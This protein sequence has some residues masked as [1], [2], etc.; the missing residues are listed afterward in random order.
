MKKYLKLYGQSIRISFATAMSYR[1]DF[2]LHTLIMI[3]GNSLFPLVTLMIYNTGATFPGWTLYEVLL[4]Q[5]IFTMAN[6]MA[7]MLFS[8]IVWVTMDHVK[9]GTLEIVLIKPVNCLFYLLATTFSVEN[10]AVVI[11]GFV[12]FM[13][14]ITHLA[15]ATLGMWLM[16]LLFFITGILVMLSLNLLMAATSFKWVAN[17]RIPELF[18]SVLRFANYPNKIFPKAIQ[19]LTTFIIPVA[20]VSCFPA[21]ALLGKAEGRMFLAILPCI[22]FL[23]LGIYI[24]QHMVKLY[25]GVGG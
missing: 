14:A 20:M 12:V 3:L 24:Y 8:G 13:I 21:V 4:I 6:G 1:A 23:I 17:S 9:E 19:S 16:S 5:S 11:G 25:E 22:L 10:L 7:N 2:I 15:T 18:N